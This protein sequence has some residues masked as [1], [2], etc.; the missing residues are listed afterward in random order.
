MGHQQN[1]SFTFCT[2]FFTFCA[3]Y[4]K[5]T[6]STKEP[7]P[8]LARVLS[9]ALKKVD[10]LSKVFY[11]KK[12]MYI[13]KSTA[14]INKVGV[15][16]ASKIEV[17]VFPPSVT[18]AVA[19]PSIAIAICHLLSVNASHWSSLVIVSHH[20]TLLSMSV[21]RCQSVVVSQSLLVVVSCHQLLLVSRCCWLSSALSVIVIIGRC[22]GLP[23]LLLATVVVVL[24]GASSLPVA[25]VSC[26]SS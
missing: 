23:F 6:K 25:I 15:R 4:K 2:F 19:S 20:Q 17:P 12:H 10:R 9:E 21:S 26:Q 18:I 7:S 3:F 24:S 5:S 11:L 22:C 13:D 14:K 8:L 1:P 16:L